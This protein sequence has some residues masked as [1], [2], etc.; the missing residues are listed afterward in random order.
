MP[1]PT[2]ERTVDWPL[3][4][5]VRLEAAVE[6]GQHEA[7]AEAARELE[8]LGVTV[9]YRGRNRRPAEEVRRER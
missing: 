9:I 3:W 6:R 4:W 1:T 2:T 5:F 7:A 8:R